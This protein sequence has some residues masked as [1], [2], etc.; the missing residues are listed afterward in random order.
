MKDEEI[1]VNP[2]FDVTINTNII[3]INLSKARKLSQTD[4]VQ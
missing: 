1:K 4:P 3:E 2:Q